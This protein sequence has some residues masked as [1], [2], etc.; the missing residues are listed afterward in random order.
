MTEKLS[1]ISHYLY[2]YTNKQSLKGI[3]ENQCLWATHYK[4]L[5]DS[6]EIEIA[7]EK[8]KESL[9]PLTKE[10]L[11]NFS[12]ESPNAQEFINKNGG[13]E[14]VVNF[15]N[16][17]FVDSSF[18]AMFKTDEIYITS[19]CSQRKSKNED[20]DKYINENGLLSQWRA[21]GGD[22]GYAIV[23]K[24]HKLGELIEL[25]YQSF[26]YNVFFFGDIIYSDDDEKYSK[27]LS[28]QVRKIS[29][30]Q[31]YMFKHTIR[32]EQKLPDTVISTDAYNSFAECIARYKHRGFKEER[33]A[34]II[35]IPFG[36]N[37]DASKP[38]KERKFRSKNGTQVP[39]IELFRP[40]D[41]FL[42]IRKLKPLPIEKI[43]VG[44]HKDKELR[45][46]NLRVLLRNTCIEVAISD[47]PY[48][49]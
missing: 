24:T 38:E 15:Y 3:L 47:I 34:R 41:K 18:K 12:T 22:G 2:H 35:A 6:L 43:I 32:Q 7:R 40:Y 25:E 1:D 36:S 29:I 11:I 27:E 19:F 5:N 30:F 20:E 44:P 31:N 28:E 48:I 45:A 14:G 10:F 33:E 42:P 37:N 13:L 46:A 8:L 17:T 9:Y 39:Y 16:E 4:F 26:Q 49:N 23:F 21:Y